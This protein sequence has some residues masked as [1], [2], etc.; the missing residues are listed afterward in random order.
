MQ[1]RQYTLGGLFAAGIMGAVACALI[2]L[3]G[4]PGLSAL[5]AMVLVVALARRVLDVIPS[6]SRPR[7]GPTQWSPY[8][9]RR[10]G[11]A[12]LGLRPWRRLRARRRRDTRPPAPAGTHWLAPVPPPHGAPRRSRERDVR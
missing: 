4:F 8:D 6:P 3:V 1:G 5:A 11:R 12:R 10:S 2:A 9:R 7:L